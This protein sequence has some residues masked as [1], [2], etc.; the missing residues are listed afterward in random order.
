M[1]SHETF[2]KMSELQKRYDDMNPVEEVEE[3]KEEESEE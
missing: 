3:E 1:K 2:L